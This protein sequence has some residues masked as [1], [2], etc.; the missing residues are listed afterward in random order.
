MLI[1]LVVILTTPLQLILFDYNSSAFLSASSTSGNRNSKDNIAWFYYEYALGEAK[2][3]MAMDFNGTPIII[4]NIDSTTNE[5]KM[6]LYTFSGD[7]DY[8]ALD[9]STF[10]MVDI[11][12]EFTTGASEFKKDTPKKIVGVEITFLNE[13]FESESPISISYLNENKV[14]KVSEF[15]PFSTN[16]NEIVVK[17]TPCIFGVNHFGIKFERQNA[18]GL[19]QI[20]VIYKL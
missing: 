12:C 8:K 10:L 3:F 5:Q 1:F 17:K 11:P 2:P 19:K 16:K 6:A 4:A 13:N 14:V 9:E 18:F 20:K 15:K 7:K